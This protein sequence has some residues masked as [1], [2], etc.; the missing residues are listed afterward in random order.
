[1]KLDLSKY[2]HHINLSAT[3]KVVTPTENDVKLA[4][5]SLQDVRQ[6]FPAD[7]DMESSPDLLYIAFAGYNGGICNRNGSGITKADAVSLAKKFKNKYID[8]EHDR[9]KIVGNILGYGFT[10]HGQNESIS[11]EEALA[12]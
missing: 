2:P 9:T 11:E 6:Y 12:C 4:T 3:I 1:M 7:L 5:A 10:K 8:L